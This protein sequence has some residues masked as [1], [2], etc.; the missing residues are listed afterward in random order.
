VARRT[1]AKATVRE[2]PEPDGFNRLGA[3]RF[4]PD[5]LAPSRRRGTLRIGLG[6]G[7]HVLSCQ[8]I[9][10]ISVP[11]PE[12][13]P[14]PPSARCQARPR[15]A[16]PEYREDM[17]CASIANT[18]VSF[19]GQDVPVCRM[20][21]ASYVRW[22]D[23]AEPNAAVRWGWVMPAEPLRVPLFALLANSVTLCRS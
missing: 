4:R 10:L 9:H 20:H 22:A 21:E 23:D 2:A 1:E 16:R 6:A 17:L 12:S 14:A 15:A 18:S 7:R 19:H 13:I 5:A 8:L 11:V 3:L